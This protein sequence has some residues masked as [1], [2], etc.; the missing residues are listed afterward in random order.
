MLGMCAIPLQYPS[1]FVLRAPVQPFDRPPTVHRPFIQLSARSPG[2]LF[3]RSFAEV[4]GRGIRPEERELYGHGSGT[5]IGVSLVFSLLTRKRAEVGGDLQQRAG[6]ESRSICVFS[7]IS[8][9]S[10]GSVKKAAREMGWGT[11]VDGSGCAWK[12]VADSQIFCRLLIL[13]SF[14]P[15]LVS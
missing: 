1:F 13:L 10:K 14:P 5:A 2:P 6:N 12:A 11:C 3:V 15:M 4:G 9:V 8:C 7:C